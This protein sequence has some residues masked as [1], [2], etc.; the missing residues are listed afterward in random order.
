MRW[1][2]KTTLKKHRSSELWPCEGKKRV[3]SGRKAVWTEDVNTS[4]TEWY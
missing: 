4:E 3:R 1:I 2:G